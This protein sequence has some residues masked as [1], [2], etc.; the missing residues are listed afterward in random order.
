[1]RGMR[2]WLSP[3]SLEADINACTGGPLTN[4][5]CATRDSP[6]AGMDMADSMNKIV[7]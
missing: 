1:M 4:T 7:L 2:G 5:R 6:W 3:C